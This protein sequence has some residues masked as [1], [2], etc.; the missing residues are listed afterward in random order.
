MNYSYQVGTKIGTKGQRHKEEAQRGK[1]TKAQSFFLSP[2][3]LCASA[4]IFSFP[5]VYHRTFFRRLE[6]A[7][8]SR[9]TGGTRSVASVALADSLEDPLQALTEQRP[10][11]I[12][13]RGA[14]R[15]ALCGNK[16][17]PVVN[18]SVPLCP[19]ALHGPSPLLLSPVGN[20]I[21]L[22]GKP[23]W[24]KVF[25]LNPFP[26][27]FKSFGKMVWKKPFFKRVSSKI[28]ARMLNLMTLSPVGRGQGEGCASAPA[29]SVAYTI[30]NRYNS[31]AARYFR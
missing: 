9:K 21:N 6:P 18:P 31:S 30:E 29:L 1:G 17:C 15:R 22:R 8:W 7:A 24:K 2:L 20:V 26:K 25:P 11:I 3:C 10:P 12:P 16:E 27:T 19:C 13:W 5:S 14:L 28:S 4:P 23:F